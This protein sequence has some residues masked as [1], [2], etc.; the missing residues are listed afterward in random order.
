MSTIGFGPPERID[1]PLP[2]PPLFGLLPAA[3]ATAA[4]V[5][6]I[7]DTDGRGIERWMNGVAVYPYPP[8]TGDVFDP[9]ATGSDF[10]VKNDGALLDHP[11]FAAMTVHIAETCTT[12][13]VWSQEE[14]KA[15]AV[16]ALGAIESG[17]IAFEFMTG[18]RLGSQPYLADGSAGGTCVFPNGDTITN[19][20]NGLQLL[21]EQIALS[22]RQGL[23]HCSPMTA[24]A[25][26][27]TGFALSDKTGVIRTI[28]GIVV[29]PDFGYADGCKKA[30]VGHA[31]PVGLSQEWMYATGPVD[32]R[33]T[34]VFTTPDNVQQA[35][36]R[37]SGGATTGK[38]NSITYRAERYVLCSWDTQV[39]AAVMVDR[40]QT[41][42]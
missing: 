32:I 18:T 20:K 37:G 40:C 1:G 38:P 15:R 22:R 33:R 2:I 10:V 21:E 14:F 24:S 25:L 34:N 42:C 26:M 6:I 5:Q 8:D 31:A 35:V 3:N 41:D 7:P 12:T 23:I 29:I 4:G 28:N 9:C 36:D 13:H 27:G 30:P 19:V 17:V 16:A 11:R 39:H